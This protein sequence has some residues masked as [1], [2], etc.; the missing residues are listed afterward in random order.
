MH[1]PSDGSM[2]GSLANIN[3]LPP[4]IR[5]LVLGAFSSAIATT[6]LIAT[7]VMLTAFLL[8]LLLREVP[9]RT[10]QDTAHV[11]AD[12]AAVPMPAFD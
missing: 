9:L 2:T 6:F 5:E 1:M 8:S 11:L 10:T 3:A 4:A 7:P 12:D